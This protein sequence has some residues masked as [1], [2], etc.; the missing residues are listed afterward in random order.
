ML[1]SS[2][3]SCLHLLLLLFEGLR[4]SVHWLLVPEWHPF[5]PLDQ[6]Q[7]RGSLLCESFDSLA[8]HWQ[9]GWACLPG[10]LWSTLVDH[11]VFILLRSQKYSP[12]AFWCWLETLFV[13]HFKWLVICLNFDVMAVNVCLKSYQHFF[14]CFRLGYTLKRHAP[15]EPA[16]RAGGI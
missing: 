12:N 11:G 13:D 14:F 10:N 6:A 8:L 1:F 2:V 5:L 4:E 15:K 3:V 16:S 9:L 7:C